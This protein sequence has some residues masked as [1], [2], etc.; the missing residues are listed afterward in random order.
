M[1]DIEKVDGENIQLPSEQNP[2]EVAAQAA[3]ENTTE[4][5]VNEIVEEVA[6]TPV[7]NVEPETPAPEETADSEP[8][9]A[10]DEAP[11]V[12]EAPADETPAEVEMPEEVDEKLSIVYE[13]KEEVIARLKELADGEEEVS[14][15]ERDY[16]KA[17]FY[18]IHKQNSEIVTLLT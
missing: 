9:P 18:K 12:D 10:A 15:Q 6:D 4:N 2:T 11:A 14:R 13:T 17:Q 16:L 7:E 8:A 5:V 1:T 3:E